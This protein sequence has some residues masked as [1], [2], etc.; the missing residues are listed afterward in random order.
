MVA[1]L[2]FTLKVVDLPGAR[3]DL[4]TSVSVKSFSCAPF[5]LTEIPVNVAVPVFSIVK[6]FAAP[7]A[8]TLTVPKLFF[9]TP[10]TNLLPAG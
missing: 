4:G 2:N 7:I 10:S 6:V 3:L 1:G 8:P 5:L 9:E